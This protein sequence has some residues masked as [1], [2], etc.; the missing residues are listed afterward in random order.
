MDDHQNKK[1]KR[2]IQNSLCM[3]LRGVSRVIVLLSD[4]SIR[5]KK[6][7]PLTR[8]RCETRR[9]MTSNSEPHR[10]S[11]GGIWDWLAPVILCAVM[12]CHTSVYQVQVPRF[13]MLQSMSVLCPMSPYICVDL[14]LPSYSE[15]ATRSTRYS[16]R[17]YSEY[18]IHFFL[19]K[20]GHNLE[21]V[22]VLVVLKYFLNVLLNYYVL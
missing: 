17:L 3:R 9:G 14:N 20:R 7:P 12:L 10:K 16:R 5:N 6:K 11:F 18:D 21:V 8:E 4:L 13:T 2:T 19:Q 1:V 22:R 15:Y